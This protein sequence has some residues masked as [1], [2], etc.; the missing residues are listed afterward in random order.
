[1]LAKG[2]GLKADALRP[3]TVTSVVYRIWSATRVKEVLC[4]QE[5]WACDALLGF[6]HGHG[7]EDAYWQ[8]ALEIEAAHA[9][10]RPLCGLSV[11]LAKAFDR[12]PL[13]FVLQLA[14]QMGMPQ[15][16]LRALKAMYSQMKR[17]FKVGCLVGRNSL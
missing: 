1:M 12:V 9:L 2:D 5:G 6:K 7:C 10:N 3:I 16:V 15:T 4:W 17:R 8:I 13:H 11:D 14:E